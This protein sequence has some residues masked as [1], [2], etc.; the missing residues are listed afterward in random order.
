MN[1]IEQLGPEPL[2]VRVTGK[3][4]P[5]AL[6]P[7]T[8]LWFEVDH[9]HRAEDGSWSKWVTP[10]HSRDDVDLLLE[11]GTVIPVRWR[12]LRLALSPAVTQIFAGDE[13]DCP[14][15]LTEWVRQN[16]GPVTVAEYAL[17]A[18][19]PYLARA[20]REAYWMP[21]GHGESQPT[22][23]ERVVVE[24]SDPDDPQERYTPLFTGWL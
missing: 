21:P 5:D 8:V 1:L 2:L 17:V 22:R 6:T 4:Q 11:D 14:P 24:L 19:Q 15:P 23:A 12:A 20:R 13:P 9:G 7:G 3:A 18:D 16:G 10:W